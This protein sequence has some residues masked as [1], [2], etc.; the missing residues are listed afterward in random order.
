M[1]GAIFTPGVRDELSKK[2][3][4]AFILASGIC[5][6]CPL[7]WKEQLEKAGDTRDER[8]LR[9]RSCEGCIKSRYSAGICRTH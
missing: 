6:A 8:C 5:G 3:P 2:I 7:N 9:H 1:A 4:A